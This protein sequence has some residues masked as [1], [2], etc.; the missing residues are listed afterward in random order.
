MRNFFAKLF[1]ALVAITVG[2]DIGMLIV[3]TITDGNWSVLTIVAIC[4][5]IIVLLFEGGEKFASIILGLWLGL[6]LAREQMLG[7]ASILIINLLVIALFVLA[8]LKYQRG[9]DEGYE[10]AE[11]EEESSEE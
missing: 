11:E 5:A 9:E 4:G 8:H 3:N 6:M 2:I 7:L 10:E 1:R